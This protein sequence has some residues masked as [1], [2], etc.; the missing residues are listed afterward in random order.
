MY[1]GFP[2]FQNTF[3]YLDPEFI[4]RIDGVWGVVR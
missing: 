4:E 3:I 1:V 2:S